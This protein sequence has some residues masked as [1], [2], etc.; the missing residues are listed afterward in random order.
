MRL[1][2]SSIVFLGAVGVLAASCGG[3]IEHGTNANPNTNANS[4]Q[5]SDCPNVDY[6]GLRCSGKE[7]P[8]YPAHCDVPKCGCVPVASHDDWA[9]T[10]YL[11]DHVDAANLVID[12]DGSFHWTMDG[13]DYVGGDC[14]RWM[15]SQPQSIVLLPAGT[16]S[17]FWSSGSSVVKQQTQLDVV[18]EPNGDLVVSIASPGFKAEAQRWKKGRLCVACTGDSITQRQCTDPVEARCRGGK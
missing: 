14:G 8:L 17:F 5:P 1:P 9:G 4:A 3:N 15:K 18:G 16:D 2:V 10:Y 7:T 13:C 6:C 12:A 11:P